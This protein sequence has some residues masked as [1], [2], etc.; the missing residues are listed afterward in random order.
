MRGRPN[1]NFDEFNRWAAILR[2]YDVDVLNP[3]EFE[4]EC[5]SWEEYIARDL[6]IMDIEQ[7]NILFKLEDHHQSKGGQVELLHFVES[8]YGVLVTGYDENWAQQFDELASDIEQ[9]CPTETHGKEANIAQ[10]DRQMYLV[11]ALCDRISHTYRNICMVDD[12]D[13]LSYTTLDDDTRHLMEVLGEFIDDR[14]LYEDGDEWMDDVFC[15][16]GL[17]LLKDDL[18]GNL[19]NNNDGNEDC[20]NG[21]AFVPAKEGI[22]CSICGKMIS[23][24]EMN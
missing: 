3:A 8:N 6:R 22:F 13:E 4:E 15:S 17:E 7:P 9:C 24:N 2:S 5:S 14:G 18:D 1:D 23:Y 19:G 21:H 16:T 12:V 20:S 10:V 11:S